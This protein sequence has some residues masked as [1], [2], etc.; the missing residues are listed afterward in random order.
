[1]KKLIAFLLCLCLVLSG[2]GAST[3]ET[4]PETTEATP[5]TVATEAPTEAPT[6]AST[7]TIAALEG[8]IAETVV[9]D[10]GTFKLTAKEID[11]SDKYNIKIKLLAENNS[12]KTVSFLGSNFSI[13]GITMY[14][15]FYCEV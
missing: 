8:T 11:Y 14:C 7:E 15:S 1:M 12:D 10:D 2:C 5:T 6:N 9:Y 3:A 4:R 13:N